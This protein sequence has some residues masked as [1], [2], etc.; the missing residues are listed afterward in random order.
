MQPDSD[1]LAHQMRL[2]NVAYKATVGTIVAIIAHHEIVAFRDFKLAVA[3]NMGRT[4]DPDFVLARAQLL[5]MSGVTVARVR[6]PFRFN[7]LTIDSQLV[8]SLYDHITGQ[9]NDSLDVVNA[10]I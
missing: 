3:A 4:V 10:R 7:D 2:R 8:T 9:A 1:R 5:D 6:V